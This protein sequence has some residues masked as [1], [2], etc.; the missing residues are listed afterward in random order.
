MSQIIP[1]PKKPVAQVL[2][3]GE[4]HVIAFLSNQH[5]VHLAA[6]ALSSAS[7]AVLDLSLCVQGWHDGHS[8]HVSEETVTSLVEA[9]RL[10][11]LATGCRN[12][13]RALIA[14][15]CAW[16]ESTKGDVS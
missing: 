6:R 5:M 9:L 7:C 4:Q 16:S 1:F 8:A 12:Q 10:S 11:I 3:E 2:S 13:D 15:L 14:A